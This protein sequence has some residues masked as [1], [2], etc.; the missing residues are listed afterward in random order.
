VQI[1]V[2]G[3]G[4]TAAVTRFSLAQEKLFETFAKLAY[5]IKKNLWDQLKIV[6][7]A[8]WLRLLSRHSAILCLV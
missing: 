3:L 6:A 8:A 2:S 4:L 7:Q 5:L 1:R